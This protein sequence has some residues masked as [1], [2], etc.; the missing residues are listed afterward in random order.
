MGKN[1]TF[2]YPGGKIVSNQGTIL[3]QQTK[4][5]TVPTGRRWLVLYGHSERDNSATFD[6]FIYDSSGNK[7]GRLSKQ[8]AAGVTDVFIPEDA[9]FP[10]LPLL[11]SA[12]YVRYEFGD[13]QTSISLSLVVLEVLG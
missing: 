11:E 10:Q 8:I 5:F 12:Y 4:T 13:T 2:S 7:L 3:T 6:P 1:L 9:A